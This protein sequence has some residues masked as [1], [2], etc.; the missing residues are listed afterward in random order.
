[1]HQAVNRSLWALR[2][3][4]NIP[5]KERIII[6]QP[7]TIS[8]E[9]CVKSISNGMIIKCDHC[10]VSITKK[11]LRASIKSRPALVSIFYFSGVGNKTELRKKQTTEKNGTKINSQIEISSTPL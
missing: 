1:M 4:R 8:R 11:G 3:I 6:K 7:N 2:V 10:T 5:A 9:D